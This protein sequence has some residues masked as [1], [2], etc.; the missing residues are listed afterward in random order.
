MLFVNII[1][2]KKE[3][4]RQFGYLTGRYFFWMLNSISPEI[5]FMGL[6]YVVCVFGLFLHVGH[7]VGFLILS[8][9]GKI[10]RLSTFFF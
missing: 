10:G 3:F 5:V 2:S 4:F 7:C 8:Y 6:V 1:K 9:F